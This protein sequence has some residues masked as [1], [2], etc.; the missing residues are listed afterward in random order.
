MNKNLTFCIKMLNELFA[1]KVTSINSI[2]MVL[3]FPGKRLKRATT[4]THMAIT[5]LLE[6]VPIQETYTH[7]IVGHY[8]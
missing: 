5:S 4:A 2:K 3:H 8:L 1:D 7:N 6:P